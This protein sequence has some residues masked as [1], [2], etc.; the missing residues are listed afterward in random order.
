MPGNILFLGIFSVLAIGQLYLGIRHKTGLV[1]ISMLLGLTSEVLGYIAR[2]LL[3]GDPFM[4]D[5]FL[6][7]LICLT[8]GPVF[9]AAAIYLCLGRIVVV[10][11]EE[12]SRIRARTYTLI[13][14]GCDLL[15]LVVQAVGGGMAASYPLTNKYMVCQSPSIENRWLTACEIDM[16]THILVAGLSLQVASLFAFSCCSLEFLYRVQSQKILL[17]SKFADL[18][19]S[20]RFKIFLICKPSI[21]NHPNRADTSIA[22]GFATAF[23]FVRTVFR[24]VELSGGFSGHLANSEVQFMVLDGVMVIIACT[25]LTVFH[26]GIGFGG[27]WAEAKFPFGKSVVEIDPEVVVEDAGREKVGITGKEQTT[28]ELRE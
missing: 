23:L 17:N 27:R 14:M 10:Y 15:S 2:V 6:W 11:G 1:C 20:S 21:S 18:Y 9:M 7:Y 26:P 3:N 5:Y 4:R 12:I 13:F 24:S 16:G 8:L 22:L 19:N 28:T 25:C